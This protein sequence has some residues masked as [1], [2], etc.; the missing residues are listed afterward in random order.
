MTA[1]A[2][3]AAVLGSI[4]LL[5]MGRGSVSASAMGSEPV[6][7][8]ETVT[9]YLTPATLEAIFPGADK[10]GEVGCSPPAAPIYRGGRQVG[11]LFSTWDVTQSKGF[12]NRPLILLVGIDL[13]GHVAA[14]RL[15]H[16]TEPIAIL[17][18]SDQELHPFTENY[19][20]HDISAGVDVV[21]E[22]SSS[23]LGVGSYSQRT[24]P[25][26]T[27][28]VKVDA[29]SRATTSSVLMSDAI[30]RGARIVGR[31][32]GVLPPVG[33]RAAR[34]DV[35]RFASADWPQLEAAGAIGHLRVLYSDVADKLGEAGAAKGTGGD[36]AA[37][38]DAVLVDLYVALLT[39]AGIGVNILGKTW[40][41]QYTAGRGV[42]D[43]I[44]LLAANGD[45]SFLGDGWEHGEVLDR[46]EIVQGERTIRLPVRQI[47]TLP[48][49]HAEKPPDLTERA[50]AFFPGRGEFDPTRPF[51]VKLLVAS[52]TA[53]GR[54]GFASFGLPYQVPDAYV[55]Q[56][57]AD[58]AGG[59]EPDTAKE[60]RADG[61][62]PA[63]GTGVDWRDIWR[64]H[65]VKITVLG[66]ALATLTVILF[67]QD[68]VTRRPRLHRW[69]RIGFL[70]WTLV[71][72]GWY[73]GAQLT[74]VNVIAYIHALV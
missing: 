35:D 23:V 36:P 43:Q 54:R 68:F 33:T 25:G 73:A 29:V 65:P 8:N 51:Q 12:S 64:G 6:G 24:I 61:P 63:T 11:Y 69:I 74:V 22:V 50:L 34:L 59:R 41:D 42:D 18:L 55:L 47:K 3:K 14:A 31:S 66:A 38:P 58:A 13:A 40:Y 4:L 21:S 19:K 28:S 37:A 60:S 26:A 67:L 57:A 32:R 53:A 27:A 48:F 15:V 16:H 2:T 1:K 44:M 71:W 62:P 17:G 70:S 5:A 30:V 39:P 45:Y 56:A 46:I 9:Q 52:A 72:L 49:V 7:G 20:G 10:V